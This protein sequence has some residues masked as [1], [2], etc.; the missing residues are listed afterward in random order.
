MGIFS[1][2]NMSIGVR[3]QARSRTVI[4]C[5]YKD[6]ECMNHRK[7]FTVRPF[8]GTEAS[9]KTNSGNKYTVTTDLTR[10]DS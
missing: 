6:S 10:R 7:S 3:L 2:L 8:T 9:A 4:T 1:E 5:A